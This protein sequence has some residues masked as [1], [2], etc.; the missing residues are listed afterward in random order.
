MFSLDKSSA[1]AG[2]VKSRAARVLSVAVLSVVA[3][4]ALSVDYPDEVYEFGR[5][6]TAEEVAA[7][8]IDVRPDFKG[9]PPGSGS[10]MDGEETWLE[11]CA[12]CH[13]DFGDSNEVFSPLVLGNITPEDIESGRVASLKDRAV[14]RTTIMKVSTVSTIWDYIYRA[15][16]WNA[17]KSLTPDQVYGLVAYL[18]QLGYIVDSDFVLSNENIEEVQAMMPNR[19][20][21]TTDHG[22]WSVNGKPDVVGD[23][24]TK[25]CEVSTEVTSF[26]PE[27]AMNAHG[28]LKD[29]V[30]DWGPF[31]GIQTAPEG[32]VDEAEAEESG[33]PEELL[34][35][36][37]CTGCH[38][39]DGK[40]VGPAF[41]EIMAKYAGQ[42]AVEYL[43]GKIKNGGQG[44]WGSMPMPQ[45]G[46]VDD[47]SLQTIAE[48]LAAGN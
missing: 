26:I 14:A 27:Y 37:G 17:P 6:A 30:R 28:N 5:P 9:L 16:P 25:N 33:V 40:L 39:M 36:N 2:G 12:V 24:C 47:A 15:M 1:M 31:P 3:P 46:Q 41:S 35:V 11:K 38:Q 8:D 23:P 13:G 7:W 19:N 44:V 42:D 34:T 22:L 4:L 18:L 48:W 29:Q 10:V 32:E 21:M 20:G 45:M 43:K